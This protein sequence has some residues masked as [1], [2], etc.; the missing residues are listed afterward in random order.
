MGLLGLQP[1]VSF[2]VP[3]SESTEDF[4]DTEGLGEWW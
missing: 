2:L 1:S 3:N 4:R